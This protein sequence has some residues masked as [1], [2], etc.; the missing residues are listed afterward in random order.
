MTLSM[1]KTLT[2]KRAIN[3]ELRYGNVVQVNTTTTNNNNKY[4]MQY[5]TLP[6]VTSVGLHLMDGSQYSGTTRRS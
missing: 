6:G 1:L 2:L 3:V 4:S 5:L